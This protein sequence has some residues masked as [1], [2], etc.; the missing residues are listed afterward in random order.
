[1]GGRNDD[2]TCGATQASNAPA[3]P[4]RI[5]CEVLRIKPIQNQVSCSERHTRRSPPSQARNNRRKMHLVD[6][7]LPTTIAPPRAL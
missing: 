1:M 6:T 5:A 4:S 3:L 2:S 7:M